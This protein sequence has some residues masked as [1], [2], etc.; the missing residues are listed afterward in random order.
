MMSLATNVLY[1]LTNS[2]PGGKTVQ[3]RY[4]EICHLLNQIPHVCFPARA[5]GQTGPMRPT[6]H[7]SY[8]ST[9][10]PW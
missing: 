9:L 3:L 5:S 4:E 6:Y 1:T 8:L 7:T 10:V 2:V